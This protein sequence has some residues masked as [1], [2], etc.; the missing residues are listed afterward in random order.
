MIKTQIIKEDKKPV[1][2]IMDYEEYIRLKTIEEDKSDY[3]SSLNV[4]LKNKKW[5]DHDEL[6]KDMG[7]DT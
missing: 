3:Y 7:I 6:K 4:K 5:K 2:V 1:A